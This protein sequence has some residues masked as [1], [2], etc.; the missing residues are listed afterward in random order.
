MVLKKMISSWIDHNPSNR[1]RETLNVSKRTKIENVF[2]RSHGSKRSSAS[3]T[4]VTVKVGGEVVF[5][6]SLEQALADVPK[7]KI[8]KVQVCA[9]NRR[10]IRKDELDKGRVMWQRAF[11]NVEYERVAC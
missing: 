7:T 6:G 2:I 3:G 8:T 9:G 4:D 5:T 1:E 11:A 10:H